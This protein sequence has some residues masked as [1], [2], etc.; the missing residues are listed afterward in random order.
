[1]ERV[2]ITSLVCGLLTA[3]LGYLLVPVLRALK[4]G[5]S[6]RDEGPIWHNS[7]TGTPM[8]GGIMFILG[9]MLC[10]LGSIPFMTNYSVFTALTQPTIT[11]IAK[12]IYTMGCR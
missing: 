9:A 4:A 10:L 1:M 2:I 12:K 7:K 6:I 5:Q 11:N 3:G 8:M